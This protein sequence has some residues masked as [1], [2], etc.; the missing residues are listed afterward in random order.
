MA[1]AVSN[2]GPA[3]A[4]GQLALASGQYYC[5]LPAETL[6]QA[7]GTAQATDQLVYTGPQQGSYQTVDVSDSGR[8]LVAAG[9]SSEV[10]QSP[11]VIPTVLP[12]Q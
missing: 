5:P 12:V 2:A 10:R 4:A 9:Q 7:P 3:A 8:H 1:L 11:E 6:V